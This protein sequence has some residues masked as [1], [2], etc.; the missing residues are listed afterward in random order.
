MVCT[1]QVDSKVPAGLKDSEGSYS[2]SQ[3]VR[4][5]EQPIYDG[6][7]KSLN[8]DMACRGDHDLINPD[9]LVELTKTCSYL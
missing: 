8:R 5:S 1:S 3:S 4:V 6:I 2:P 9:V 7:P